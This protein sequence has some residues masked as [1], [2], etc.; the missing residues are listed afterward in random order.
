MHPSK[1]TLRAWDD[2]TAELARRAKIPVGVFPKFSGDISRLL[3]GATQ[4]ASF[5]QR[6]DELI[7]AEDAVRAAYDA[8]RSLSKPQRAVLEDAFFV[9]TYFVSTFEGGA[10]TELELDEIENAGLMVLRAWVR[11]FAM[12][13]G[14][15]PDFAIRKGRGRPAET[16][17][18]WQL[19]QFVGSLWSIVRKYGGDLSYSCKENRGTGEMV[20]VLN[21]FRPL[22]PKGLI[23]NVLPAKTI[24]RVKHTLRNKTYDGFGYIQ[25]MYRPRTGTPFDIGAS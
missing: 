20:E 1:T 25:S 21:I 19:Q 24:Q 4:V 17:R 13:T 14:S 18:N 16:I 9:S 7:K 3:W 12:I 15:S 22:L 6:D 11:A 10:D 23:P 5:Q 8:V 2:A